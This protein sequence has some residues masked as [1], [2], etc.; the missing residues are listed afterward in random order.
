LATLRKLGAKGDTATIVY[1]GF[2]KAAYDT[3]QPGFKRFL[4]RPEYEVPISRGF[5]FL[6]TAV[7]DHFEICCLRRTHAGEQQD[8]RVAGIDRNLAED[9]WY[10]VALSSNTCFELLRLRRTV[11][12]TPIFHH[13]GPTRSW[14]SELASAVVGL[15]G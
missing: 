10:D 11:S 5:E 12:L 14:V 6:P 9:T 2:S 15:R 13:D 7:P 1:R 4:I 8:I 3:E